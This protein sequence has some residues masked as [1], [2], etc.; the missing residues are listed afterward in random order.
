[1]RNRRL[2]ALVALIA[3]TASASV[4]AGDKKK[5]KKNKQTKIVAAQRMDEH[6]R[7]A[8]ALNRFTFGPRPGEV[9]QVAAAGVDK[10]FEA[11]L[12][13]EKIDDG[14]LDARLSPLRTLRMSSSE[15]VQ[16][17]PPA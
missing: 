3:V 16:N 13:P 1:M 11:Q 5:S 7:A 2:A 4:W 6:Q 12:R 9:D 10:W 14:A 8:H 17:F 15:L